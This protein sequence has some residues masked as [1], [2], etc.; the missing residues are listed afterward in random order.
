MTPRSIKIA[1]LV[2]T[3]APIG[4]SLLLFRT[5]RK[6]IA[7]TLSTVVASILLAEVL[8]RLF[9]P[10]ISEHDG[11]F[12]YDQVLGWRFV[13][14]KEG[15]ILYSGGTRRLIKT[16]SLGFRD[17]LSD[18]GD[19]ATSKILVLG[20]SFVSNISIRAD[21]VFTEVIEQHLENTSVVNFGVN[22]YGQ[23]QEY[24]LL[25]R[26]LHKVNPDSVI[27]V[28]YVQNDFVDNVGGYWLY[29]RPVAFWDE[30]K[31]TLRLFPPP[32]PRPQG[33]GRESLWLSY[34]RLHSYNLFDRSVR[35]L[36]NKLHRVKQTKH[37]SR[38]YSPPELYLCRK[39]LTKHTKRLH[40]TLEQLLLR[41]AAFVDKR[42]IP[43]LF[44][45]A[46]SILQV[47]DRLWASTLRAFRET[48]DDYDQSLPNKRLVQFA[49][50]NNLAMLDLLPILR[51]ETRKGR[52]LYNRREQHWT[53]DGNRVVAHALL[54][55]LKTM[56]LVKSI[57]R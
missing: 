53:S 1:I 18:L 12:E 27:L 20:D 23:T 5:K 24:L 21:D 47:E 55:C 57:Q 33:T 36:T 19:K 32:R 6:E 22:G 37:L 41:I 46:P 13:P 11:M 43:L 17:N 4:V 40:K 54:D 7:L 14:N 25:T 30:E 2:A 52:A 42:H 10:Q 8:L 45:V 15:V 31:S 34:K 29:P 39:E 49:E 48:P 16:N 35:I 28:I 3:V 26:S 44:V 50:R 9:H 51:L 56:S 38:M